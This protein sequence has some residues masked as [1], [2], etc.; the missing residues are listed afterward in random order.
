MAIAQKD[1]TIEFKA[2]IYISKKIFDKRIM[3]RYS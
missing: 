2:I 1:C 3:E